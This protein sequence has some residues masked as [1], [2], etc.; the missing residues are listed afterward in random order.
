M[1][2]DTAAFAGRAAEHAVMRALFPHDATRRRFLAAVSASTA[3]ATIDQF[4]PL[5]AAR[6]LA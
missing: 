4:L 2:R 1:P 6:A 3:L 5:G